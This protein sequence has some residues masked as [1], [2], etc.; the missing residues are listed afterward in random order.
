MGLKDELN[1]TVE[2]VKDA[3]REAG[4]RSA[5]EA[6]QAERD[7]NGDLLTPGEKV[8]SV[9]NQTKHEVLAGVDKAKIDVRNN[10]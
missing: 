5:A 9:A 3:F 1:K 6:E 2:N 8:A 7:V 4:H 10:T